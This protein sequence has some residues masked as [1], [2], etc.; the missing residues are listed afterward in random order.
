MAEE[1][2]DDLK[3]A[4]I[5]RNISSNSGTE[6]VKNSKEIGRLSTDVSKEEQ[7]E[8]GKSSQE[9]HLRSLLL[10]RHKENS[11]TGNCQKEEK[12]T[13]QDPQTASTAESENADDSSET[14]NP[15]SIAG[16]NVTS[17][18][19]LNGNSEN[20][21]ADALSSSPKVKKKSSKRWEAYSVPISDSKAVEPADASNVEAAGEAK[22]SAAAVQPK[23]VERK[24]K[25]G[26]DVSNPGR[27]APRRTPCTR[28]RPPPRHA[29]R[30][31]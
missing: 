8:L 1:L 30:R 12:A 29:R 10:A 18:D 20:S 17:T 31:T 25:S 24:R 13:T 11:A 9:E 26:W 2:G 3:I 21:S 22:E 6:D 27:N 4:Q 5:E 7:L 16:S 15:A 23:T 28:P 19:A 14:T